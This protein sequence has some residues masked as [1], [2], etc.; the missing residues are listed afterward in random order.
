VGRLDDVPPYFVY[1][2]FSGPDN[3]LYAS[4]LSGANSRNLGE[5]YTYS[6]SDKQWSLVHPEAAY[7]FV[8]YRAAPFAGGNIL[9]PIGSPVERAFIL[10]QNDSAEFLFPDPFHYQRRNALPA[11]WPAQPLLW[12]HT[13]WNP[14]VAT[15]D[16]NDLW[17]LGPR[18]KMD[19]A[20]LNLYL[21]KKGDPECKWIPLNFPSAKTDNYPT[22]D[23]G[24]AQLLGTPEGLV[25]A[26]T[27]DTAFWFVPMRTLL[28]YV[29]KN[30]PPGRTAQAE[31]A[32][33][34]AP[35]LPRPANNIPSRP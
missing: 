26:G 12:E 21:F 2:L 13:P 4:V 34:S 32:E 8:P 30:F 35:I 20:P 29:D 15:T 3:H 33:A 11:R 18:Q 14:V 19:P 28:A 31:A 1:D 27:G 5:L 16:G 24:P 25:I 10:W 6:E 7:N 22:M 17:V 9:Q 23:S